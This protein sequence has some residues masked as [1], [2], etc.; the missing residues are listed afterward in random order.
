M[1]RI[2]TIM[3]FEQTA[4]VPFGND[5]FIVRTTFREGCFIYQSLGFQEASFGDKIIIPHV[6]FLAD[7]GRGT[8][9]EWEPRYGP[10][11]VWRECT[12]E[13]EGETVCGSRPEPRQHWHFPFVEDEGAKCSQ[14]AVDNEGLK[15]MLV[16]GDLD[17]VFRVLIQWAGCHAEREDADDE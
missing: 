11:Q 15:D 7:S 10:I 5:R 13:W 3:Q 16:R 4:I 6:S 9:A 12:E 14:L 2:A 8:A 1:S 17:G